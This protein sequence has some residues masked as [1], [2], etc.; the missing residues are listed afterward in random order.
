[1]IYPRPD[2][3]EVAPTDLHSGSPIGEQNRKVHW[4]LK[5]PFGVLASVSVIFNPPKNLWKMV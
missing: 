5:W 3:R 1:M 4:V 2:I